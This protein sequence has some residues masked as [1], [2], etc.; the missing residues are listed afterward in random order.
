MTT[1]ISDDAAAEKYSEDLK[2]S[3]HKNGFK[4]KHVFHAQES[5]LAG[6]RHK[7]SQLSARIQELEEKLA[8]A[9]KTLLHYSCEYCQKEDDMPS[10]SYHCYDYTSCRV[11]KQLDESKESANKELEKELKD[12]RWLHD[13]MVAHTI[14]G[15]SDSFDAARKIFREAKE[16]ERKLGIA[17]AGIEKLRDGP[18]NKMA[19]WPS[20]WASRYAADRLRLID[21]S[22]EIESANKEKG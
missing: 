11:L 15:E 16:N 22:N 19:G 21:E 13:R 6:C 17:I 9:K 1:P 8:L 2:M 18:G 7:E 12:L 20:T 10:L 4:T 14:P 5:F 3:L